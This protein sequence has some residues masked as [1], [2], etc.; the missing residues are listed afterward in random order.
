MTVA[1][2]LRVTDTGRMS[3]PLRASEIV[4][5]RQQLFAMLELL[6]SGSIVGSASLAARVEGA[7]ATLDIVPGGDAS[8]MLDKLIAMDRLL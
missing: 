6:R 3:R 5:L 7:V 1:E 2:V 8:S 4:E